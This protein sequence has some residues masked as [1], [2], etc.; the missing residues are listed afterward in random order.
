MV[1]QGNMWCQC[2]TYVVIIALLIREVANSGR[3]YALA[4]VDSYAKSHSD[5]D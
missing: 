1:S 5:S 3:V 4:L 2:M